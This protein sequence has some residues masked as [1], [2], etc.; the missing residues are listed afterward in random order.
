MS[1]EKRNGRT[2]AITVLVAGALWLPVGA[3]RA[4]VG[5]ANALTNA[6]THHPDLQLA[7]QRTRGN[8]RGGAVYQGGYYGGYYGGGGGG[9][10]GG[11]S[12][13]GGPDGM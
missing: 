13:A 10:G 5:P 12:G 9:Y 11:P 4:D 7:R 2:S 3:G 8:S 6:A 1:H